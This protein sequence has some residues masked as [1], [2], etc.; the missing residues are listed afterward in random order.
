MTGI[1]IVAGSIIDGAVVAGSVDAGATA[2]YTVSFTTTIDLRVGSLVELEFPVL[3]ASKFVI[4]SASLV[5]ASGVDSSSTTV[6]VLG[7]FVRLVVAGSTV[8]AGAGISITYGTIINPAAQTA[9]TFIVRTRQ[10]A[11]KIYQAS[12]TIAGPTITSL[13]MP[14]SAVTVA[15]LSYYGGISTTYVVTF[16]NNDVYIPSASKLEIIFPSSARFDISN[17]ALTGLSKIGTTN[18]VF[19]VNVGSFTATVTVGSVPIMAGTGRSFTMSGIV[20][21]GSS[22]DEFIVEYCTN[23]WETYTFRISD[24]AGNLF[25]VSTVVPGTPIV[26]KPL[27][28]GRVRPLLKDPNT[29][30]SAM[31]TLDTGVTI[32]ATGSIEVVFPA[33]Y[34]VSATAVVGVASLVGIPSSS[35]DTVTVTDLTVSITL[36]TAIP[37]ASGL[38]F[39]SSGITTPPLMTIGSYTVRTRDSFQSILEESIAILGEGCT[40]L[41]ECNG[42]GQCTLLSKRCICDLGWGSPNDI[43]E[44]RSPDCTTRTQFVER[45]HYHRRCLRGFSWR[46]CLPRWR[47]LELDSKCSTHGSQRD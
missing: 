38:G 2:T 1:A 42:H 37:A 3:P 29:A 8:S 13:T 25:A 41:N 15:P 39:T 35:L 45:E 34:S 9:G 40:Y 22:C 28:F 5:S 32:P 24:S 7:Q 47:V 43:A 6:Q 23:T 19:S 44:Y 33:G 21:P 26:K 14:A 10:P 18:T 12:P 4:S 27:S 31:V 17:A 36:T 30:T 46:R 11:G 16:D 20:N